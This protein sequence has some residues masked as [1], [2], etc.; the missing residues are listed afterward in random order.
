MWEPSKGTSHMLRNRYQNNALTNCYRSNNTYHWKRQDTV[1]KERTKQVS[2]RQST[3]KHIRDFPSGHEME[4]HTWNPL[5][6]AR[7]L[8]PVSTYITSSAVRVAR[9]V[10]CNI[11][12]NRSR[13]PK[14]LVGTSQINQASLSE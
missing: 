14:T 5:Q 12:T 13:S 3:E 7:C 2:P 1:E 4:K 6:S 8:G 9:S 11:T 10:S